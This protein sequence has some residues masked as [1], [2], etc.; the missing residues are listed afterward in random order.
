MA[1]HKALAIISAATGL[2]TVPSAVAHS[3][4]PAACCSTQDCRELVEDKGEMVLET[5]EGWQ[6]W[7]GRIVARGKAKPSPDTKFHL[8]ETRA[9]SIICFFAPPGAS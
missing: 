3:W 8:C 9:K 5:P 6:L 4:Y 2:F 1:R 7:D